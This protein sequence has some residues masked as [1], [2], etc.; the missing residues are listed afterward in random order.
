M[1]EKKKTLKAYTSLL[2][3][4]HKEVTDALNA[5]LITRNDLLKV[6]LKQNELQM[7]Q[8][9]LENG[10]ILAKMAFC[11]YIGVVYDENI[12][13]VESTGLK[14]TPELIYTDHQEA[15]VNRE[16]YKLLQKST[17]A[18]KY[19]TKMQKGEYMPQVAVGVGAMYLDVMGDKG[20]ANGLAFG[21]V[22]IPISGWWEAKYKMKERQIKEEQNRNMV[23]DNTEKLLL[24]MQQGHN[25]LDEAFKQVQLAENSIRQAEE[26]L[27]V[28]RD[29][30]DAGM[31][32]VSELLD[33]QAQV[34]QSN[35]IY[36]DA[37]NQYR[38]ARVNYLQVTGR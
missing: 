24:Q 33:A 1:G 23:T 29:N 28:S 18:E 20:S 36:I 16:E 4:L 37:L 26:N 21:T 2:D 32:N 27:N 14:G 6:E 34:Q 30:Y 11:Q 8:L 17:A 13:F 5:G 7:N 35:D 3:T 12:S 38:I 19:M 10:T 31:I 25:S 15:L 22:K 9:K